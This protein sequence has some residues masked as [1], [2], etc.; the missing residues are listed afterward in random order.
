MSW[1]ISLMDGLKP[2]Q[3]ALAMAMINMFGNFGGFVGNY[4]IGALK[5]A[6]GNY[7]GA[8]W[9]MGA[10]MLVAAGL[11]VAFP[12]AWATQRTTLIDG[13]GRPTDDEGALDDTSSH[14]KG[15]A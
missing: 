8:V 3:S 13:K 10:I 15:V 14:G 5:Q 2:S 11:V 12:Q 4:V 7:Y 6:S 1:I 9:M